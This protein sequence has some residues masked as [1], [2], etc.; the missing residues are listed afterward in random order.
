MKEEDCLY[1]YTKLMIA[2]YIY[3][4]LKQGC[5]VDKTHMRAVSVTIPLISEAEDQ[6][7][8]WKPP[9]YHRDVIYKHAMPTPLV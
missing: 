6:M 5:L 1:N 4:L 8:P 7:F 3:T 9:L 2:V